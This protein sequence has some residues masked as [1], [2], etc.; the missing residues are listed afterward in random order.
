MVTITEA[1]VDDSEVREL[2]ERIGADAD[3]E[4][5]KVILETLRRARTRA[6]R[7]FRQQL[8]QKR[9]ETENRRFQV[10]RIQEGGKLWVGVDP[11][12]AHQILGLVTGTGRQTLVEGQALPRVFRPKDGGVVYE[13]LTRRPQPIV[14][15]E[16]PLE[17]APIEAS[18]DNIDDL[19]EREVLKSLDR[20]L[21]D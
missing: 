7:Q 16:V 3:A 10:R 21:R 12:P 6:R 15:F 20:M 19:Y 5:R 18:I 4:I 1:S 11:V 14:R 9:L 2:A 8:G 17:L 13:R